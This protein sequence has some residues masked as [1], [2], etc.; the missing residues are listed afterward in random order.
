MIPPF[1]PLQHHVVNTIIEQY[2]NELI[3]WKKQK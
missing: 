1:Y 2:E 3:H